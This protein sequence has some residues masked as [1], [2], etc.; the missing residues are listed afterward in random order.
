MKL[1]VTDTATAWF[2]NEYP[3]DKGESIRFFGKAYGKTEVHDGFSV[4]M[5]LSNPEKHDVIA[6]HEENDRTYFAAED[7][8]WFFN[9]YDLE[10]DFDLESE[11]PIYHFHSN[12]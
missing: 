2:E 11:A 8:E 5:K 7:D 12:Q 10:V 3:L 4:G 6:K 1:T 9:G